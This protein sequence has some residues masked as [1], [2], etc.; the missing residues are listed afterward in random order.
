VASLALFFGACGDDDDDDGGPPGGVATE[1]SVIAPFGF[2]IEIQ[3]FDLPADAVATPPSVTFRVTEGEGA[4]T[5]VE[6][7]LQ[8]IQNRAATPRGFP[9]VN[10]PSF[11]LARLEPEGEYRSYYL[12]TAGTGAASV[13]V[14]STGD[15]RLTG[16]GNGSYRF[17]LTPLPA[18]PTAEERARTHTVGVYVSNTPPA[19]A[20]QIGDAEEQPAS[21]T[22]N[23]VPAGG[24]PELHQVV[25]A[26]S[27]NTCHAP[28]VRAHGRR[29]G[30]QLCLTCHTPQT[31][32]PD[33]N[34]SV[35]FAEMVHKIHYG[36]GRALGAA[37]V[38]PLI[39]TAARPPTFPE[40]PTTWPPNPAGEPQPYTIIGNQRNTFVFD[41]EFIN[42]VRNCTLC[43]QGEDADRHL[44][45]ATQQS[46]T[47]C[48]S[49]VKFDGSAAGFCDTQAGDG[50]DCNHPSLVPQGTSCSACHSPD[51]VRS[52][53]VS[54]FAL[55][56]RY[57]Y[58]IQEVTVDDARIPTVRFR[59][60]DTANNQPRNLDTDPSYTTP[61][62]SLSVRFSWPT[63]EYTNVGSGATSPGQPVAVAGIAGGARARATPTAPPNLVD[64]EGQP[65]TYA[66]TSTAPI[67]GGVTRASGHLEGHP[68]LLGEN[69]RVVNAIQTFGVGGAAATP[70]RQVVAVE[71]CN[72]CHG[73]VSAH[74]EN[75]NGSTDT[76]VVCHNPKATDAG[77]RGTVVAGES[78]IDFKVMIHQIHA[79]DIKRNEVT[80][81]GFA[82]PPVNRTPHT[83]PGELPHDIGNC[84]KCHVNESW[85]LP[86]ASEVLDTVV[87]TGARATLANQA[88]DVTIG[89]MRAVCT[90][91]HDNV[92]FTQATAPEPAFPV[93]NTLA[94]VN[95][96]EPEDFCFHSAGNV[97]DSAC[98][99]CHGTGQ[100]DDVAQKHPIR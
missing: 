47:T 65:N 86:L 12:N 28:A 10:G 25:A 22:F 43:H 42:D 63:Q 1:E 20:G 85:R 98:A 7:L 71:N 99:A 27:C 72:A 81:Y 24:T 93:C 54:R 76:C 82:P 78:T 100:S 36:G 35:E 50:G 88:D 64:V 61:G 68:V 32:D 66:L 97:A 94:Q 34:N 30:V 40:G 31:R 16:L 70:R 37:D 2:R 52:S 46:C 15:P 3:S 19:P 39:D 13:G 58:E 60:L 48:H 18:N 96:T 83:F 9:N 5:P 59:V 67:P 44:T 41:H 73:V 4:G 17:V 80:I 84:N 8:R 87:D 38:N 79:A 6:D 56:E 11:T 89:A 51:L 90:S 23:F 45:F 14:P 53:H 29:L 75:R 69:V 91:C 57:R 77:R 74:G 26:N 92:R 62:S 55:A 33:T 49:N 21:A 95:G